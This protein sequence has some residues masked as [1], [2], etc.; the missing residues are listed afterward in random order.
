MKKERLFEIRTIVIDKWNKPNL[1]VL[2][3]LETYNEALATYKEHLQD[4]FYNM[5]FEAGQNPYPTE[6]ELA[7]MDA[8]RTSDNPQESDPGI[9]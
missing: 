5:G 9:V 2:M 4:D 1:L 6:E 3:D 7:N 8:D